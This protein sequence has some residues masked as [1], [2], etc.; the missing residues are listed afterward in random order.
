[1]TYLKLTLATLPEQFETLEDL[2]ISAGAVS[3]T[4]EDAGDEPILEPGVAE[5]PLW[6][7]LK[8]SALFYDNVN[9]KKLRTKLKAVLSEEAFAHLQ[10]EP[11]AEEN[12]ALKW[13]EHFT[14]ISFENMLWIG[15]QQHQPTQSYQALVYLEPG[16]AFGTGTH[17]STYLCLEWLATHSPVNKTIIDYGCGSGILAIAA[18][19]LGALDVICV[20]NDPQALI[21]TQNNAAQNNVNVK[22][23]LPQDLPRMTADIVIANILANPLIELAPTLAA[24]VKPQ[25]DLVLAGIL[26]SQAEQVRAAYEAYISW[27]SQQPKEE[28]VRLWGVKR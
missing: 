7:Q 28:W 12:W 6:Q 23:Y 10:L 25:G 3:V 16:L 17:P 21:A 24:L 4:L 5:T 27:Q 14:P 18:A 9:Q 26:A 8:L 22:T 2:L 15:T 13:L 1:M 19:K 20:D 11:L